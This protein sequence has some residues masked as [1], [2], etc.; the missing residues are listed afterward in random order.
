MKTTLAHQLANYSS[1]F[2]FEDLSSAVVHEVKRRVLDSLG[3][4]LGA[5]HDEPGVVARRVA[6]GLSADRGAT[7]IGTSHRAPA[8]WAAFANGCIVRYLDY[9]DTYLSKE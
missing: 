7:L 3:C 4:A 6:S 1:S 8:D 9:N 2:R 5:W